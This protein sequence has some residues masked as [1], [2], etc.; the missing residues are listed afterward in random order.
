LVKENLELTNV[1]KS[2]EQELEDWMLT[3]NPNEKP[4][5]NIQSRIPHACILA[6]G[7]WVGPSPSH[8]ILVY[9][10]LADAWIRVGNMGS[11]I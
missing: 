10:P 3:D 11:E 4:P 1:V 5:R 2:I 7:G 9:N 6:V 8:E